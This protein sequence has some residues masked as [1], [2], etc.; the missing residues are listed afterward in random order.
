MRSRHTHQRHQ[1]NP[2]LGDVQRG[3]PLQ[4]LDVEYR[5]VGVCGKVRLGSLPTPYRASSFLSRGKCPQEASLSLHLPPKHLKRSSST[6]VTEVTSG[7]SDWECLSEPRPLGF[8]CRRTWYPAWCG[9]GAGNEH[10]GLASAR[11]CSLV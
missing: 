2:M 7:H 8:P 11:C 3:P 9:I 5:M 6:E 4:G 10:T 1:E